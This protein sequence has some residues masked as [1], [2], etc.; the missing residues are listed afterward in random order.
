MKHWGLLGRAIFL[1]TLPTLFIS[2]ILGSFFLTTRFQELNDNSI[3]HGRIL[4]TSFANALS[5]TFEQETG[6]NFQSIGGDIIE[7]NN[8]RSVTFYSADQAILSHA[9]PTMQ[10]LS[11]VE[12]KLPGLGRSKET[13]L[14]QKAYTRETQASIRIIAPIFSN[15]PA[16][17]NLPVGWIEVEIDLSNTIIA[18]Y[19]ATLLI[20]VV[21]FLALIVNIYCTFRYSREISSTLHDV[22]Q[23]V[24]TMISGKLDTH[25]AEDSYGELRE[26]QEGI[27]TLSHSIL[28]GH[29]ELQQNVDQA[30][31]DLRET[32]ETIEIQNIELDLAR[33]EALEASRIKSEFLANMSHEIRTPLNGVLGFTNLLLKSQLNPSQRDYLDTIQKS[34]ESL[35]AIIN[36]ILDF[37]KIEAGKLVLDHVPVNLSEVVSDVLTMLAP[38][39]YDKK[40][41]QASLFYSDVPQN[42]LG[43]PLRLRQII[44]NLVNN[45]IKFT[46]R[47]EVTVRVMLDEIRDGMAI[48]K[49]TVSDTGI[50]L[51][52]E[53]QQHLFNAFRQADTT[54]ARRFGGTG[55]GL[56]ISKHLVEQMRGQIGVESIPNEGST[57]WFTFKAEIHDKFEERS[58][59]IDHN[60]HQLVIFDEN[61]TVRNA[62]KNTLQKQK[63]KI[64]ECQDFS[65]LEKTMT[66]PADVSAILIGISPQSPKHHEVAE[67]IKQNPNNT[68]LIL[69][70]NHIDQVII[71][72]LLKSPPPPLIPKPFAQKKTLNTI[73]EILSVSDWRSIG[74]E[75]ARENSELITHSITAQTHP[76]TNSTDHQTAEK[77]VNLRILA[78]DDNPAN[79]KLLTVLLQD[80][81]ISVTACDNGVQAVEL[82][83]QEHYDLILMDIQ[84]PG[85]DGVEATQKIRQ[86]ESGNRKSPI[87]AVT[88]HALANEK[89][90]LLNSGMDD[91]VTKPINESQLLHIIK[92]WTGQD[93]TVSLTPHT[94][95]AGHK[96]KNTQPPVD[97]TL[98]VKLANGKQDLAD[99]MLAM[100]FDSLVKERAQLE[101]NFLARDYVSLLEKVHKLHGATRYTGVPHLQVS[102]QALEESLKHEQYQDI[103]Q[104]YHPLT[105]D[106]EEIILWCI[107]Y[108][109]YTVPELDTEH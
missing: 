77:S 36:D 39:A 49:I 40:L 69:L 84:M 18:K 99:D 91:Y 15:S 29:Q 44:T 59:L 4:V 53:Q 60:P 85:M 65:L 42:I 16:S 34:S 52:Q 105:R 86:Q 93:L 9:G 106:I 37:S 12:K 41:E 1:G 74:S 79:L 24:S 21:I 51:N 96:P 58:V 2:W 97:M 89:Q 92:H 68:P 73:N 81:G 28:E 107:K 98:G 48:I 8:I 38:M 6:A 109:N 23:S 50:G 88:A 103:E 32:L 64:T 57:F 43:D 31:E 94:T 76:S 14:T 72:E 17:S 101:Q 55:L 46:E 104:L 19:Q 7:D 67:L 47:G 83:A 3:Y 100:L 71:G 25:V 27:N 30:S 13:N 20:L 95:E 56:V 10:P 54:T 78:V 87:I 45:A 108:K 63:Y 62:L 80:L 22:M 5:N 102:A 70:G 26:L 35:L 66:T 90:A 11:I 82:A 33:K 75:Q 61:P